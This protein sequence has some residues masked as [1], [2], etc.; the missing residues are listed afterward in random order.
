M[1]SFSFTLTGSCVRMT[2]HMHRLF[3]KR[4]IINSRGQGMVEAALTF[5]LMFLA[6]FGIVIAFI[7]VFT[8]NEWHYGALTGARDGSAPGATQQS[9]ATAAEDALK[10]VLPGI[11]V[12]IQTPGTS[13][14]CQDTS[15]S[16][17]SGCCPTTAS[18]AKPGVV[19]CVPPFTV[20]CTTATTPSCNP[21]SNGTVTVEVLGWIQSPIPLPGWGE[22]LPIQAFDTETLQQVQCDQNATTCSG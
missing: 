14:T 7:W 1:L 5:P 4:K 19:I 15:V 20:P 11:Q 22:Y 6:M 9:T 13:S 17:E 12:S 18:V 21:P 16:A 8:W 3:L 2:Q 10:K